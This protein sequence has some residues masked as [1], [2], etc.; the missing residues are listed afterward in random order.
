MSKRKV[1]D[2]LPNFTPA[3]RRLITSV[4]LGSAIGVAVLIPTYN[5]FLK[6]TATRILTSVRNAGFLPRL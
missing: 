2:S 6:P 5:M 1:A 4:A 3:N